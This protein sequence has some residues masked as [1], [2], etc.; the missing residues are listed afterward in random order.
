ME[1]IC[2]TH[3]SRP[4]TTAFHS[5]SSLPQRTFV[6]RNHTSKPTLFGCNATLTNSNDT[7]APIVQYLPNAP[8]SSFTNYSWQ[9]ESFSKEQMAV[10]LTNGFNYVTQGNSTL[11]PEWPECLGCAAIDRSPCK[12]RY[13]ANSSVSELYDKVLPG[14][15]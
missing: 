9:Q 13:A 4:R 14:W 3:T 6:N 12:G 15:H 1:P 8:Y 10:I 7:R 2:M 5:L 11:D